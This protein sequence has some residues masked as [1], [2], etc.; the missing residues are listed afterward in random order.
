MRDNT[1]FEW[2]GVIYL[3]ENLVNGKCY[4]GQTIKSFANRYGGSGLWWHYTACKP[5]NMDIDR[6]GPSNFRVRILEH[7]KTKAELNTLEL[8]Y[9]EKYKSYFPHGYNVAPCGQNFDKTPKKSNLYYLNE[10]ASLKSPEGEI[11]H[12]KAEELELFCRERGLEQYRIWLVVTK[13]TN[14]YHGWTRA[15]APKKIYRGGGSFTFYDREG[16]KHNLKCLK[17][18]C[19]ERDLHYNRMV[20]MS[21]GRVPQSQGYALSQKA[22]KNQR[23]RR[24]VTLVRDGREVTL[25]NVNREASSLGLDHRA[26]HDLAR[27]K[28]KV[29]DGWSLK[30]VRL[31]PVG[32]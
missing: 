14:R 2:S 28:R 13:R 9:A 23:Q 25:N 32:A 26:V 19:D 17:R 7:S 22:F 24:I 11:F 29:Y 27:G 20:S 15:D 3:I 21:M 6:H 31:V 5:L 8:L 4:I 16:K 12:L 1:I 10:G 18:F 30:E